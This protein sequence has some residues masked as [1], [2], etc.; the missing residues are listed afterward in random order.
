MKALLILKAI[1]I[2]VKHFDPDSER[3]NCLLEDLFPVCRSLTGD[4]N[5]ETL[6]RLSEVTPLD[7]HE[8]QCE[9]DVYD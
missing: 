7:I 1:D 6:Q 5:R 9:T 2:V 8:I 3:I 4:G